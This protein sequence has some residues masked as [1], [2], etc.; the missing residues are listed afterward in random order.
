MEQRAFEYLLDLQAL[1]CRY[2]S[3]LEWNYD[4]LFRFIILEIEDLDDLAIRAD[5][6]GLQ[7]G[8]VGGIEGYGSR[9]FQDGDMNRAAADEFSCVHEFR[10]KF[11]IIMYGFEILGEDLSFGGG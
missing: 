1:P 7:D 9:V 2:Q 5:D 8:E 3:I 4:S 6:L 11:K 10:L